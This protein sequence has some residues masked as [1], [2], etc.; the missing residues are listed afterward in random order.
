MIQDVAA[1]DLGCTDIGKN[2]ED[3]PVCCTTGFQCYQKADG[4]ATCRAECAKG[5]DP[6]DKDATPWSCK[7]LGPRTAGTAPPPDY[8]IKAAAW[9]ATKCSNTGDDCS[10]TRCCKEP[11]HQCFRKTKGWSACKAAC[12]PG[13]D[14][15]DAD[16]HHWEC[17]ALGMPTPGVKQDFS[18]TA[19]WVQG[20]C[21]G[22]YENCLDSRCCKDP[23]HSCYLKTS[24]F[25]MCMPKCTYGPL[26]TD[27]NPDIWNC[28]AMGG[29][30][31]GIPKVSK[32]VK[33]AGWVPSH[34]S[35]KGQN[36]NQTMCC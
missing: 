27:K 28:T 29:R 30:T 2:C 25:A 24:T 15:T 13:P 17:E 19:D 14:P 3:N 12:V 21:S 35:K 4:W 10:E 26:L 16:N 34:C 33:V 5:R 23:G 11:G 8:K 9:V 18:K 31:P 22:L 32:N 7:A 6:T 1:P 36:C 20:K